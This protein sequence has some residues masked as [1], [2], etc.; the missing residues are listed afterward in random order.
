[1]P[2]S[3]ASA[4]AT[5]H[6]ALVPIAYTSLSS[7]T[8]NITFSS[9]PQIYQDLRLV[10]F[11]RSAATGTFQASYFTTNISGSNYSETWIVGDGSSAASSRYSNIS[12]SYIGY[13]P[14]AGATSGIYGAQTLDLLNYAN[15]STFK[16]GLSRSAS[17]ANGSGKTE[18]YANLIRGTSGIT[19]ITI[20]DGGVTGFASGSTFELFGVR[21]VGQ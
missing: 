2:I 18:L 20:G 9:I 14:A 3:L 13:I 10:I 4:P 8:N 15:T 6:G 12:L 11:V 17:D 5:T 19:S 7:T 16:S 21:A 1:M